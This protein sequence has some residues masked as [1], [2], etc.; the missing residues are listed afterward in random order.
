MRIIN[1]PALAYTNRK[2][3]FKGEGRDYKPLYNEMLRIHD[4]LETEKMVE[5]ARQFANKQILAKKSRLFIIFAAVA[6]IFTNMAKPEEYAYVPTKYEKF[7]DIPG[8]K[9]D[10]FIYQNDT[11]GK[12]L[13][14]FFS[15]DNEKLYSIKEYDSKTGNCKKETKFCDDGKTLWQIDEYN[16]KTGKPK[17]DIHFRKDGKTIWYITEYDSKTGNRKKETTFLPGSTKIQYISKYNPKTGKEV[18]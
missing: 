17:K 13:R 16:P 9:M 5:E 14:E 4:R 2:T 15:F 12:L 1:Q 8:E 11:N 6:R 7:S 3:S 10:H 18:S